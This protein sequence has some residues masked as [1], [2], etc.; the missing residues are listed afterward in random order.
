MDGRSGLGDGGQARRASPHRRTRG[1]RPAL[2]IAALASA[3]LVLVIGVYL[4]GKRSPEA[5]RSTGV[6]GSPTPGLTASAPPSAGTPPSDPSRPPAGSVV[7]GPGCPSNGNGAYVVLL[8]GVTALSDG[9]TGD[10][11]TGRSDLIALPDGPGADTIAS[12]T[13]NVASG[14]AAS[15]DVGVYVSPLAAK[16]AQASYRVEAGGAGGGRVFTITPTGNRG[17]WV[18]GGRHPVVGSTVKVVLLDLVGRQ[19]GPTQIATQVSL[20]CGGG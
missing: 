2:A 7:A 6:G 18:S 9:W 16:F 1:T 14:G 8:P 4:A 5:D 20:S 13:F 10:G 3:G 12:W 15:C 17:T 11:C 19:R